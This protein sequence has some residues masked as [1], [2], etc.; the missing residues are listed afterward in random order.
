MTVCEALDGAAEA[1]RPLDDEAELEVDA[2]SLTVRFVDVRLFV[3]VD[4]VAAAPVA[5]TAMRPL[6]ATPD[7]MAVTRRARAAG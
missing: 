5:M 3:L 6:K 7:A 2:V 1:A 4:P